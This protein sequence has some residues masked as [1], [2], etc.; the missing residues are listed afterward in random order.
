HWIEAAR[1]NNISHIA[2]GLARH[3]DCRPYRVR[4]FRE[5]AGRHQWGRDSAHDGCGL[6]ACK[7][8]QI[9]EKE[10]LVLY[11]RTAEC[12]PK[13]VLRKAPAR[14][15]SHIVDPLVRIQNLIA[16]ELEEHAVVPVAP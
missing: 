8:F 11:D 10:Q 14:R 13:L 2:A 1:L 9:A 3:R 12:S 4:Q 6:P 5:V 7:S 15:I 16:Q